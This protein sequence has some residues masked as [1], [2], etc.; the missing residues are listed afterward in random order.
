MEKRRENI[1]YEDKGGA[2]AV[3][4]AKIVLPLFPKLFQMEWQILLVMAIPTVI[5]TK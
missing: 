3:S 1:I 2:D 4:K 5:L